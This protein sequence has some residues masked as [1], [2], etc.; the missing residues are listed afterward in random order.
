[1]T[2]EEFEHLMDVQKEQISSAD[3]ASNDNSVMDTDLSGITY[4]STMISGN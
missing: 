2:S 3:F 1:M 4:T